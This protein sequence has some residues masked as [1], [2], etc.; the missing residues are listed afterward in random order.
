MQKH[1][2]ISVVIPT[3]N[4]G[5]DLKALLRALS[6]QTLRPDEVLVVDSSS[7]DNTVGI[8]SSYEDVRILSISRA[9]FDHGGTRHMAFLETTGEYVLFLT[10]DALPVDSFYVE[11]LVAPFSDPEVAMASGRQ[12]PK[13]GARR[14]EQLVRE[15]NYPT[16]SNIRS[17]RDVSELGI[18]TFFASDVCSAY[19]R[20][21]YLECGGFERPCNTN[22]D[23]LMAAKLM[24]AGW[25]VAYAAKAQVLHSHNLTPIEQYRRNKE[26]GISLVHGASLVSGASETREGARLA[27]VVVGRLVGEGRVLELA[28]F[29]LDCAARIAGNR[30]GRAAA[31]RRMTKEDS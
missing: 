5:P 14:F 2:V 23:M 29:C 18:K 20:D 19:R 4:A 6:E 26:V 30:A 7:D 24:R 27:R 1:T 22:E 16:E 21:A 11:S 8:A 31:R 10:Q 3:L 12:L 25:K 9:S 17:I 13:P 28:A 15:F